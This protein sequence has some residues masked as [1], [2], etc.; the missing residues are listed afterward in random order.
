MLYDPKLEYALGNTNTYGISPHEAGDG[1][2]WAHSANGSSGN[3]NNGFGGDY[4]N[5]IFVSNSQLEQWPI[6][7]KKE[8]ANKLAMKVNNF[9]KDDN[10]KNKI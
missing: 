5:I 9:F 7:S 1:G 4:N 8:V 3:F 10:V 2:A 6:L